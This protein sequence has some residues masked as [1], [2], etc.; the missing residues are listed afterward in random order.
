MVDAPF[1]PAKV[2][3]GP[4]NR[5]MRHGGDLD[6]AAERFGMPRGGWLDLST[7]INPRPY[8]VGDLGGLKTSLHRLPSPSTLAGLHAA[9]RRAYDVPPGFAISAAPGAEFLIRTLPDLVGDPAVLVETTYRSYQDSWMA[10]GR[11]LPLGDPAV[12]AA[13]P[14]PS[15]ILV[16]PNNPDGHIIA[17]R[18][19]LNLAR[20]RAPG[21]IV[22]ID[23]SY[24]EAEPHASIVPH[25]KPGDPVLVLKSFGKFFGLPG[26][27]LGFAIG[28]PPLIDRI[29]ARLGDWPVS[30]PAIAIGTVALA[31][32]PWRAE[33]RHW[34]GNQAQSLDSVL[35]AARL[36]A[37]GGCRLF[38]IVETEGA[39]EIH[40]HL[41]GQGIWTR[42][43]DQRPGL[44]RFGLPPDAQGLLRLA[45][46]L[47]AA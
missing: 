3:A 36:H 42:I 34:L 14:A 8:P 19:V 41:A 29:A 2:P 9:A 24:A 1:H 5:D 39:A 27:R 31:D 35:R 40:A 33:T 46:A 21:S 18:E 26:L 37:A 6:E 16:N 22:V 30:G 13:D 4:G 32:D 23:E 11:V 7:G 25:L 10:R 28:P 15:A 45:E 20:T 12:L 47:S 43:F 17:A 38:R 44:M